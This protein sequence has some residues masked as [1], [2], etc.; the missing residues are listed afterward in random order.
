MAFR[1]T[2]TGSLRDVLGVW[3][4]TLLRSMI[5]E[6]PLLLVVTHGGDKLLN[7]VSR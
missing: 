6:V 7:L 2:A 1:S 3:G 4:Y 5:I